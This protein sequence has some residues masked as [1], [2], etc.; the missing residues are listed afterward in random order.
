MLVSGALGD[1][2]GAIRAARGD[3]ALDIPF[4]SDCAPLH[5]LAA[6]L[7]DA[8]PG[9]RFMRRPDAAAWRPC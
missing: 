7:V 9:L 8:A 1:H 4:V 3:M 2:G 5:E 6:A